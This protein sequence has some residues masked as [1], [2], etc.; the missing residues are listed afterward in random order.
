M[1]VDQLRKFPIPPIEL[2]SYT[3]PYYTTHPFWHKNGV[4]ERMSRV[5]GHSVIGLSV[6]AGAVLASPPRAAP[7][8]AAAPVFE[9]FLPLGPGVGVRV[10][11]IPQFA[12]CVGTI[13]GTGANGTWQVPRMD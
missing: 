3:M 9:A 1:Q 13:V 4:P 5:I 2:E 8:A 7:E 6:P 10:V 11:G 12:G